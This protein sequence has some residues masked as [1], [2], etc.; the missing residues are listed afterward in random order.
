MSKSACLIIIGLI[1]LT[2]TVVLAQGNVESS[3][4]PFRAYILTG[5]TVTVNLQFDMT[6]M[7]HLLGNF[8][9]RLEWEPRVLTYSGNSGLLN[10]FTGFVNSNEVS[11]GIIR[12]N[13]ANALG[14][15]GKFAV[16]KLNFKITGAV[17][18]ESELNLSYSAIS[19]ALTF[20]DLKPLHTVK[21]QQGNG[22]NSARGRTANRCIRF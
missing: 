5:D 21:K 7:D 22:D 11:S 17:N 6:T 14:A 19:S 15:A 8:T 16:L 18:A 9:G 10:G 20:T 12:F 1:N 13:G 4:I 3:V 2:N